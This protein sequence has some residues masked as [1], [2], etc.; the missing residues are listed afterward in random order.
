MRRRLATAALALAFLGGCATNE[1]PADLIFVVVDTLRAD[2]VLDPRKDVDTPNLDALREAGVSFPRAYSHISWTLPSHASLF[3]SRPPHETGVIG[4][5]LPLPEDLPLLAPH[6]VERGYRAVAVHSLISLMPIEEGT[7]IDRGFEVFRE[8]LEGGHADGGDVDAELQPLLA[9]LAARGEPFFLFAHYSD[10]HEPYRSHGTR[11]VPGRVLLDGEPVGEI[12]NLAEPELL[13]FRF[14]LSPGVHELDIETKGAFEVREATC[15]TADGEPVPTQF[16]QDEGRLYAEVG[17]AW[18][19]AIDVTLDLWASDVPSLKES[20]R[21][22]ALEV[23]YVDRWIGKLFASLEKHG[24]LENAVV[25]FTSDHGE[26]LGEHDTMSHGVNVFDELLH[27]PLVI[28]P[29]EGHPALSA[30]QARRPELV[31]HIDVVPTVLELLGQAALPGQEGVSLLGDAP[32]LH[33]AEAHAEWIEDH[34]AVFDGR[35]K[36][37]WVPD[38]HAWELYDLRSDPHEADNVLDEHEDELDLDPWRKRIRAMEASFERVAPDSTPELAPEMEAQ[39]RAMGY[40]GGEEVPTSEP[41]GGS[42]SPPGETDRE[43]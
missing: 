4:N 20:L 40:T 5:R 9:D 10:P 39:M 28:R 2:Y 18:D 25:V 31:R 38:R 41:A 27:V 42:K 21:R 12:P 29:P 3:S 17:H 15:T 26:G 43:R 37:V 7:G 30:L 33:E 14:S 1:D 34:Y 13:Q 32:R 8:P 11:T 6:L 19:H 36:L 16:H 22:Y 24:L 23:E 35:W